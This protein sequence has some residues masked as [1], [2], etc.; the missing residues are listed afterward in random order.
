MGAPNPPNSGTESPPGRESERERQR[1][2]FVFDAEAFTKEEK[3]ALRK[4]AGEAETFDAM[5]RERELERRPYRRLLKRLRALFEVISLV[6]GAIH[7]YL[8]LHL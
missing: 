5:L 4:L 3:A 8:I 7:L 2:D 6:V 1:P